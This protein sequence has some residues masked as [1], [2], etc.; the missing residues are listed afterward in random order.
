MLF[1][2][3]SKYTGCS[4]KKKKEKH[5]TDVFF[6]NSNVFTWDFPLFATMSIVL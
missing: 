6:L 2:N 5:K 4:I 1:S 3:V